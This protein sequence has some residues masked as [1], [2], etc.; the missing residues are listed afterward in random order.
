M[1]MDIPVWFSIRNVLCDEVKLPGRVFIF[2]LFFSQIMALA[3]EKE[4]SSKYPVKGICF[5]SLFTELKV[6]CHT[7]CLFKVCHS[8][9]FSTF[10][11]SYIHH[12]QFQSVFIIPGRNPPH[13]HHSNPCVPLSLASLSRAVVFHWSFVVRWRG[14]V[15]PVRLRSYQVPCHWIIPTSGFS[16]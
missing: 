3:L 4:V 1:R 7:I 12:Y 5:L 15:A 6:T 2:T 10:K 9:A 13:S 16:S 11:S 8:M 14:K